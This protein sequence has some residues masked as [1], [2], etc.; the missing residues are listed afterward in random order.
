MPNAPHRDSPRLISLIEP[1][2]DSPDQGAIFL[3]RGID[4]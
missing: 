1:V 4:I 3:L 2:L